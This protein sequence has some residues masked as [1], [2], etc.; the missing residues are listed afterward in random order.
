MADTGEM[1]LQPVLASSPSLGT[2]DVVH[3]GTTQA[4]GTQIGTSFMNS[5]GAQLVERGDAAAYATLHGGDQM[6]PY[7]K[8]VALLK[9]NNY[10]ASGVPKAGWSESALSVEMTR[11]EREQDARLAASRANLSGTTQFVSNLAGGAA[12]PINL[13]AGPV[14]GR[15]TGAVEAGAAVRAAAGAAEGATLVGGEEA[16]QNHLEGH[17]EDTL[18]WQTLRDVTLGAAPGALLHSAFGARPIARPGDDMHGDAGLNVI[19]YLERSEAAAKRMGVS[20]DEVVSPA[21]AVGRYQIMPATARGLGLKGDDAEITAQLKNPEVN[22]EMGTKVLDQ[23]AARYGNDP[24]AIAVAY[25]AGPRIADKWIK[26]GRDDRFLPNE[27]RGYLERLRG[28]PY[29]AREDA[30]RLTRTQLESDSPAEMKAVSDDTTYRTNPMRLQDEHDLL[31]EQLHTEALQDALPMRDRMF[32]MDREPVD[33]REFEQTA[34]QPMQA[35]PN[36]EMDAYKNAQSAADERVQGLSPE[37]QEVY[38]NERAEQEKTPEVGTLQHDEV[39]KGVQAAI[40]CGI[41]NGVTYGAD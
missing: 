29:Q 14:L 5:P 25:N 40:Q 18:S 33:I 11:Q 34:T 35:Q 8:A 22:K 28:A 10:D 30:A 36:A 15:L 39:T 23:L 32:Q 4:I 20:V 2:P 38:N 3:E 6:V 19:D 21:G 12:D 13:A 16:L 1:P 17:D 9:Q 26:G 27:T 24:E 31:M 37:A 41:V 7:D